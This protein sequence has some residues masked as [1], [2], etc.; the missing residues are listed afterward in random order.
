VGVICALPDPLSAISRPDKDVKDVDEYEQLCL[1]GYFKL[2]QQPQLKTQLPTFQWNVIAKLF[3]KS[4]H[5]AS[6]RD[7]TSCLFDL[8]S[9]PIVIGGRRIGGISTDRL[10]QILRKRIDGCVALKKLNLN[11]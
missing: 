3:F 4:W 8:Y 6:R 2:I 10:K 7:E 9:Q 5:L 11:I 1:D